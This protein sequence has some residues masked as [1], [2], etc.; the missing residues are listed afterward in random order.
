MEMQEITSRQNRYIKE[1][2]ALKN[3]KNRDESGLFLVEGDKNCREALESGLDILYAFA[4]W[5]SDDA[6]L[7]HPALT[8]K[9]VFLVPEHLMEA[10]SDTKTPQG[11]LLVARQCWQSPEAVTRQKKM[12]VLLDGIQDPG[13]VGT[14]LRTAWAAGAGGILALP[15]S[16]DLYS[17]K[18]VR[19][20]MG[21]L[22]HLPCAKGGHQEIFDALKAHDY[23]VLLA[24]AGGTAFDRVQVPQPVAWLLGSEADGPSLFWRQA[25]HQ[26]VAI[27]MAPGV[28]SLNVAV[29]AGIL[30]FSGIGQ[31]K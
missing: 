18:V 3:K 16:S 20:A 4:S 15:G 11:L 22:Y 19:A 29:A 25:E 24:D 31:K 1:A 2:V 5:K 9:P 12:V 26:K 17:P 28:D 21:A 8:K 6:L 30:F 23:T 7:E 14:I 13:N 10:V 27:P